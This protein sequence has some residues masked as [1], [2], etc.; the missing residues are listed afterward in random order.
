MS[1]GKLKN[2]II[3]ILLL[4]CGFLLV[5]V[6]PARMEMHR[7]SEETTRRLRELMA[8]ADVTLECALPEAKDLRAAELA[9][10]GTIYADV[11]KALLGDKVLSSQ[12]AYRTEYTADGGTLLLRTNGFTA[13]LQ[14]R[15]AAPDP[16]AE[17]ETLLAGFGITHYTLRREDGEDALCFFAAPQLYGV[18]LLSSELCFV[19]RDGVLTEV[20]GLPL[21]EA[22]VTPTGQK[23]CCSAQDAL[24]AF[25]GKRL[26][27]GWVG[28]RV[29]SIEQG[30]LP[31]DPGTLRP[32]WKIGTDT[33]AYYVD[34]LTRAV[35][36]AD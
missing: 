3:L 20:S 8:E 5:L 26:S 9:G 27:L 28:S 16:R 17:T 13:A 7:R 33:G 21:R 35:I 10:S 22:C 4:T 34:G 2:L 12:T 1:T 29:E 24:V 6:L 31:E 32:V 18:P 30:Y 23:R 19:Y 36:R 11:V 14:G 15:E 25:W